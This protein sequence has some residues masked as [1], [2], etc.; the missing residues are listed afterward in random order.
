M[1]R[2]LV[3]DDD[4]DVRS[5]VARALEIHGYEVVTAKDGAAAFECLEKFRFDIVL[6]DI[7]MPVMDGVSL[8]LKVKSERPDIKVML[9]TGFSNELQRA[10]N[11]GSL[12]DYVLSKPFS[13]DALTS[14]IKALL[15]VEPMAFPVSIG[16]AFA[17]QTIAQSDD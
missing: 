14:A 11:I 7:R 10:H 1:V 6:S 13:I 15:A 17:A 4:R 9:M 2:I 5:F 12:V 3:V 8:A 16:S